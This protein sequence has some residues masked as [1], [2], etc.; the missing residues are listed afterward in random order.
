MKKDLGGYEK[1]KKQKLTQKEKTELIEKH[2]SL[3][4]T[5]AY[6][7]AGKGTSPIFLQDLIAA[8]TVGLLEAIEA[9]DPSLMVKFETF[10]KF[11]IRGAMFDDIRCRDWMPRSLRSKLREL[12]A[13]QQKLATAL[14]RSPTDMEMAAALHMKLEDYYEYVGSIQPGVIISYEELGIPHLSERQI[15]DYIEDR[16]SPHPDVEMQWK[17]LKNQIILSLEKLDKDEQLVMALYYYEGLTLKEIA[18]VMQITESRVSQIHSKT[19]LKLN[20]RLQGL[21]NQI[22]DLDRNTQ[23]N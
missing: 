12:S 20:G 3:V 10:A 9:Y 15:I 22:D 19:L 18:E 17:E 11:R 21:K 8:G 16:A 1:A 13:L 2:V 14:S 4:K 23:E 7:I 6:R 5:T